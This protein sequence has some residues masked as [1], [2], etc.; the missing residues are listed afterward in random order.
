MKPINI[1]LC[2][3]DEWYRFEPRID[4][5]FQYPVLQFNWQHHIL[6]K[7]FKFDLS[8]VPSDID[9]VWFDE[10]KYKDKISSFEPGKP[11]T[12]K[13]LPPV[14]CNII[15]PTLTSS[16][17]RT[18]LERANKNADLVLL[19]HDT[20]ERWEAKCN[21]PARRLAYSVNER[22]YRDRGLKR[23]IDVGFYYVRGFSRER[24]ALDDW[25]EKF[26]NRKGYIYRST[27]GQNVGTKYA[28]LLART[29]VVVHINRTPFTRPPRIFD[30][31]A[32]RS[33]LL[34]NPMPQVSGERFVKDVHYVTFENPHSTDYEPFESWDAYTDGDCQEIVAG[35]EYLLDVGAWEDI[36]ENCH[37]YVLACHTWEQRAKELYGILLD[38]FPDLRKNRQEWWYKSSS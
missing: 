29:K 20:L 9:V 11:H 28:E 2:H 33:A 35:L 7:A 8:T 37:Q 1:M 16:H 5:H 17:F 24:P 15:Y 23:D 21:A 10:G 3:R 18:R 30:C 13:G 6:P 27:K 19:D 12:T 38:V 26:C 36:A 22:Y 25:L 32:S 31:G 14:I 4:G 34:S